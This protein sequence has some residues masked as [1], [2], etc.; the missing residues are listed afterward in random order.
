VT[1]ARLEDAYVRIAA[2][3]WLL[4][5]TIL[6]GDEALPRALLQHG[7]IL[8]GHRVPLVGP[9]GIFK[10]RVLAEIP[11]SIA[12]TTNSPYADSMGPD[13]LLRYSY[14][15]RDPEH[16]ENA[17]LRQAM[18]RQ[19]PLVYFHAVVPG[20]YSAFWP[21]YVV[22]DDRRALAFR[23]AVDDASHA[24]QSLAKHKRS[25]IAESMDEGRRI[26][27]TATVLKRLHQTAFREKVLRAYRGQC[28]LCR[29][30]HR[31]LLDAAHI[32]P[33]SE[34]EGEPHVRNGIA[35][36]KLHH[37][38]FDSFFIGIQPD[39]K[40][41]IRAD[42]LAEEDGPMLLHGLQGLHGTELLIPR[43]EA[44]K[45]DRALLEKRFVLFEKRGHAA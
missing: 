43:A 27:I 45:P 39:Y 21:V 41:V 20:R 25:S 28:A 29:L 30:R 3:D 13:G 12:T 42:V 31:E 26:Y 34:P 44:S 16:V 1:P 18:T 23:I 22:G 2:F 38:A 5:Q 14:R 33:D 6:A 19:I 11:L 17:G 35:L 40:V 7:F 9:Q 24:D 10:P 15:G 36:C 8:D 37:A 32:I 4:E